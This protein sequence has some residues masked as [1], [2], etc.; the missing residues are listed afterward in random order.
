MIIVGVDDRDENGIEAEYREHPKI[1][2][3]DRKGTESDIIRR[4]ANSKME[5]AI[6]L[7]NNG[8]SH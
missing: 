5:V 6:G 7:L 8:P 1:L 4:A 3:L 2:V